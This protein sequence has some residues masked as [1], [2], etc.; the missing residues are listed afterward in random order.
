MVP[1]LLTINYYTFIDGEYDRVGQQIDASEHEF[2]EDIIIHL[3]KTRLSIG[4]VAR[5]LFGLYCPSLKVWLAPNQLLK[6][7]DIKRFRELVLMIRFRPTDPKNLAVSS[8]SF[9]C[10]FDDNLF[11]PILHDGISFLQR[12]DRQ[13]FDYYFCQMRATFLNSCVSEMDDRLLGVIIMNVLIHIIE[14]NLSIE[15]PL[16]FLKLQDF[17][18][19]HPFMKKFAKSYQRQ[20]TKSVEFVRFLREGYYRALSNDE[21]LIPADFVKAEF[22]TSLL[23]HEEYEAPAIEEL[24]QEIF[25]LTVIR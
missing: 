6:S 15:K 22:I 5:H 12:I 17:F 1:G 7:L 8:V 10:Q 19:L 4:P 2:V 13:A 24:G 23:S 20:E 11:V 14:K 25:P 16:E 18:P 3:C 21:D 9:E